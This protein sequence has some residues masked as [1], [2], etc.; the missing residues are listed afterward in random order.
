MKGTQLNRKPA[1]A[2]LYQSLS[3]YLLP[4]SASR[5]FLYVSGS[6]F[7]VLQ[8]GAKIIAA[9]VIG[10]LIFS[11]LAPVFAKTA[12]TSSVPAQT[13]SSSK[14]TKSSSV[15]P[16]I[17][18]TGASSSSGNS[19]SA[20]ATPATTD[21][22]TNQQTV[23]PLLTPSGGSPPT[24]TVTNPSLF[25]Y[26]TIT[27]T[28]DKTSGALTESIPLDIPPG[29]NG[30][31]PSLS[32]QYNSQDL[33]NDN[34]VGYGWS[35]PIPYIERLNKLGTDQLYTDNYFTSSLDGELANVF[36]STTATTTTTLTTDLVSYWKLDSTGGTTATD[37]VGTNPGT[38]QS[39]ASFT[40][41][42]K[43]NYGL[44]GVGSGASDGATILASSSLSFTS[45]PFSVSGWFKT[46]Q[47][48][49]TGNSKMQ[50]YNA[51]DPASPY[52]GYS[53]YMDMDGSGN[54]G[55]MVWEYNGTSD[56]SIHTSSTYNDGNWHYAVGVVSSSGVGTL[57]IDGVSQGTFNVLGSTLPSSQEAA[58]AVDA[59]GGAG[60]PWVGTVDEIGVWSRQLTPT[61]VSQLYN[62]GVGLTYP[63]TVPT[64][65]ATSTP[66]YYP[67]IDSGSFH[68]Y[69]YATSTNSWVM[70]DKSGTQYFFGTTTQSQQYAATNPSQVY[71]WMLEEVIDTNGNTINYT[72][73]KDSNQIYPSRITYTGHASTTGVMAITFA[74]STRPDVITDYRSTF[75]ITTNYRISEINASINGQPVRKYALSYSS[76]NNS[77]RSLLTSIQETGEDTNGNLLTL[78]ALTLQYAST[79]VSWTASS[80]GYTIAQPDI[81]AQSHGDGLNDM[82]VSYSSFYEGC[83]SA[84]NLMI[85]GAGVSSSPP[86]A[87]ACT[88]YPNP[89][90]PLETGTRVVDVSGNGFS[91]IV[92]ND[93]GV[94]GAALYQNTTGTSSSYSFSSAASSTLNGVI[95]PFSVDLSGSIYSTGLFGNLNGNGYPSYVEALATS[96]GLVASTS[97]IGNGSA[98]TP[99]SN[100]Y[101]VQSFPSPSSSNVTNSQL[102]DINGD[103]LDDWVY[104]DSGHTYVCPNTGTG[105][106]CSLGSQWTFATS[107]YYYNSSDGQYCDRG[108]RFMDIN[109]DGLP[110]IVRA[111]SNN[112]ANGCEDVNVNQVWLNTGSGWATSTITV[113]QYISYN[114]QPPIGYES[115]QEH[116]YADWTGDGIP[117]VGNEINNATR[118]DVL[119]QV[120]YPKGGYEQISYIPSPQTSTNPNLPI[121]LLLVASTTVNDDNGN[122]TTVTY[123][124]N[125]GQMY[126]STT[127]PQ[128][129]KF[130]GFSSI[131]EKHPDYTLTS[132]YD[133][134]SGATSTAVE[135]INGY[136]QIG[137]IFRQD[138]ASPTGTLL[139]RAFYEWDASPIA[140]T[141]NG[142]FVTLS[143]QMTQDFD[144]SGV[145][146]RDHSIDYT[147]STTTGDLLQ[148]TDLGE[149]SGNS[150]GSFSDIGFDTRI[151]TITYATSTNSTIDLP[152]DITLTNASSTKFQ[153][154]Q[155]YYDGLSLRSASAGN[156]TKQAN[157]ITGSTYASTT[158]T[159]NAYGLVA[160][161]TDANSNATTYLY[162]A[163][164][165][166]PA[167]TTNALGQ[168]T[169]NL[170]D[171]ATGD[172]A[173]TTD[174]NG[175]L[176]ANVFDPVGRLIQVKEPD[177]TTPTTLDVAQSTVYTDNTFPSYTTTTAYL[178][179]ATSTPTYEYFDG[180][181]RSIQTR[182]LSPVA[183]TYTVKD[184]V[185]GSAGLMTQQSLPYFASGS[186]W[187][188]PTVT[189]ALFTNYSYDPLQRP[190]SMTTVV[191][192]TGY[193]YNPWH[194][195]ITDPNGN[196][197]DYWYDAYQNLVNVV[198]H[199]ATSSNATTTYAYDPNNDITTITDAAG[200]VRNFTYD[201]LNRRLTAQDLHLV[202]TSTYGTWT[203][204]YDPVG[205]VTQLIDAKGQTTRYT[206][207]ALNRERTEHNIALTGFQLV[208]TYD[209][210]AD[211][212]GNICYASSTSSLLSYSYNALR[213]P[214]TESETIM[215]TSTAFATRY[216]YDQQGNKTLITYPDGGAAQYNY[217]A[218]GL[219]ASVLEKSNGG[220][221]GSIIKQFSYAP[222]NQV[223]LAVFGSNASTT[224]TYNPAL[225]YRLTNIVTYGTATTTSTTSNS[226]LS[227]SLVSYWKFDES[228]G[229]AADSVGSNT[230]T[231]NG[232][233][234]FGGTYG[235]INNGIDFANTSSDYFSISNA[236]QSGL[237]L[238][239]PLTVSFWMKTSDPGTGHDAG[240]VGKWGSSNTGYQINTENGG[241]LFFR[242]GPDP[243]DISNQNTTYADHVYNNQKV[244]DGTWHLITCTYD[245]TTARIYID[246][247]LAAD[248]AISVSLSNTGDFVAGRFSINTGNYYNGY[249][250]EIGVWS[251]A[252]SSGD[253][254]TLYNSGVG[255]AYPFSVA[256]STNEVQLQN[257]TYNYD[258]NGNILTRLDNSTLGQGQET[259]YTYDGLNRLISGATTLG[260]LPQYSQNYAYDVL[261]NIINGPEGVYDY[262]GSN[263]NPDAV[264]ATALTTNQSTSTIAFDNSTLSGNGT[265][266]SSLTFAHTDNNNT[267]GLIIVIVNEAP[268]TGSCATDKITG[269]TYNGTSLTDLGYYV[270]NTSPVDGAI[271]TYYAFAPAQGTHNVVVS[272]SASCILYA[273]A[274]TYIGVKQSGM[275]DASGVGNPL[276][277]SGS[278]MFFQATT[279]TSNYNA[280]TVLA[281]VPSTGTSWAVAGSH[282]YLRQQQP[283]NLYYADSNG[284]IAP[285]GPM[286]LSWFTLSP[287]HWL[288]NYFS[289]T[290]VTSYAGVTATTTYAYDKNGNLISVVSP[291]TTTTYGYDY[292]NRLASSSVRGVVTT[293]GYDA[294]G[295]RVF[296]S[297]GSNTTYYPNEYY[298][299][300]TTTG[301]T[302]ATS[303]KYV[304][305]GST[306]LATIDQPLPNGIATGTPIT[307]YVHPDN[308]GS[309]N[310]TSDISGNLAQSFDYAPYG[311]VLANTNTGSTTAA[312]QYIGQ[313]YD[314]GTSLSYLN[315]RYYNS[316]Q[317]QFLSEDPVFFSDPRRQN[318]PDPQSLN[319]YSY[320]EDNPI[321]KEDPSGRQ[322][323]DVSG[324]FTVPIYGV[325]VGPTAGFYVVPGSNDPL[326]YFGITTSLKPGPSGS[327]MYSPTGS[328]SQGLSGS[329]SGFAQGG[330]IQIGGSQNSNGGFDSSFEGG[331]GTAGVG[332]SITYTLSLGQLID[333]IGG[334]FQYV[335]TPMTASS[336]YAGNV[337][338]QTSQLNLNNLF[339]NSIQSRT[340]TANNF[341]SIVGSGGGGTSVGGAPIPSSNSLWVTPS[342]AV[343]TF[344]GKTISGP[345]GK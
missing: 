67:R 162:D 1:R 27:P 242:L 261:G 343:V 290:P 193:T 302:T 272:A 98:W 151:K 169:F 57:Y 23:Q 108:I 183:G 16:A 86:Y 216:V 48:A 135:Q 323:Y 226:T 213:L 279:T 122:S 182:T 271:K 245:G 330:G 285:A 265:P 149:V 197:K 73:N 90:E 199:S 20:S 266:A 237:A 99:S 100:F 91:D 104:S 9:L 204:T 243:D 49:A 275:P 93:Q 55:E 337:Q 236:A 165:Y 318:L 269:V 301:T 157:W 177:L 310:V 278:V 114:Y 327:I 21:S 13:S 211:G 120:N 322:Y 156:L 223:T 257:L 22:N 258:P 219:I 33:D 273:V 297:S 281:G 230:L 60:G 190:T 333:A 178:S 145:N 39:G 252:L 53:L 264:T 270:G 286:V 19:K 139:K 118:Q 132:Y 299:V 83:G 88:D 203:Y 126:F 52:H 325:P 70:T 238:S 292:D 174:P 138:T 259:T 188:S 321:I 80:T 85:D 154:T 45:Y 153:E 314:A 215:G 303:T 287:A 326:V 58:I 110:D 315:N 142:F 10:S 161:S 312:R 335:T 133:Q 306:L 225:L 105:W 148:S 152:A 72:Y 289:I 7:T 65:A 319:S 232:P 234:S 227:N 17:T 329:I 5:A 209:I 171:Y 36:A 167:T 311:S 173:T 112:T 300:V 155:N 317:G 124:Y 109:G 37:T 94:D 164:N 250:D 106:N 89:D 66:T 146:H 147:Y 247:S 26:Q 320:S 43:I 3:F 180:L 176:N 291:A 231:N 205:N 340:S 251:R 74:T 202:A 283:G 222:T 121:S 295:N 200:N 341:N 263:A 82:M 210:C 267:N 212:I 179:A 38:L 117:D 328:P 102:I 277:D 163:L 262:N 97:Y 119:T 31:Q 221:F 87:W 32:L 253:V 338:N 166:Y 137:H 195:T 125:G 68:K 307:R 64:T 224:Y 228:S 101:P 241:Y 95:P 78:P 239:G 276:N 256:T 76:G 168:S 4:R 294:F 134:G 189:A 46:S 201:G 111:Y 140:S 282:T 15:A 159:Y 77:S 143:K 246:G 71:K 181:G 24:P 59:G 214:K 81:V 12:T 304:Y 47:N 345:V 96:T 336:M 249:L 56:V 184:T 296:Q 334:P 144:S 293:Y 8:R 116:E 107:T 309:T 11:P 331:I 14:T 191:G 129:R 51:N 332:A 62:G 63:F 131:V 207:D 160:T 260:G 6:R 41:A 54:D 280:W 50:I 35:L 141:S 150:D 240:I 217:N 196:P 29:R 84:Y 198:E 136:P 248:R 34:E 40:S 339:S 130:A 187:M 308:L 92:H 18:L 255:S 288:A 128:D 192:T 218:A 298:S 44:L 172:V 25:T 69:T 2:W 208:Y 28:V 274:A 233:T 175:L 344:G 284:P 75:P 113:P 79:S 316:S 115:D 254:S 220:S 194:T 170:Y 186:S 229:N 61:E 244:N 30:M 305:S 185:Y 127:T 313:Y 206:Y 158:K 268:P 235:K 324:G 123:A 342:G 103:G 42:G